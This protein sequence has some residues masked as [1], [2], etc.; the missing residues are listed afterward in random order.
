MTGQ[1]TAS[2]LAGEGRPVF[3]PIGKFA[4]DYSSLLQYSMLALPLFFIDHQSSYAEL[5]D[6]ILGHLKHEAC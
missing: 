4:S 6:L 2:G 3:A 1:E 5:P